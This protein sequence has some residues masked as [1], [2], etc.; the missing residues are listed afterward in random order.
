LGGIYHYVK[1]AAGSNGGY[2]GHLIE[3]LDNH[4]PPVKFP[5]SQTPTR[6]GITRGETIQHSGTLLRAGKL[7]NTESYMM[8][9]LIDLITKN[10]ETV[11]SYGNK[12]LP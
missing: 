7:Y 2:T 1:N 4:A 12:S 6:H 10:R 9:C 3:A 8:I 11:V 5:I